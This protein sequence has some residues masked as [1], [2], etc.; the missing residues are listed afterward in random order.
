MCVVGWLYLSLLWSRKPQEPCTRSFLSCAVFA[1]R[2]FSDFTA[3][4]GVFLIISGISISVIGR[5]VLHEPTHGFR[6]LQQ[7]IRQ[8]P[9]KSLIAKYSAPQ[10]PRP[11]VYIL[12]ERAWNNR[13]TSAFVSMVKLNVRLKSC[14][15]D[16][17]AR[18]FITWLSVSNWASVSA[19]VSPINP[20]EMPYSFFIYAKANMDPMMI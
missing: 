8:F 18:N 2:K 17:F 1:P 11:L 12:Q 19:S 7:K 14:L 13:I 15:S 4:S 9:Q 6:W 3:V 10:I 16:P 5:V 20:G